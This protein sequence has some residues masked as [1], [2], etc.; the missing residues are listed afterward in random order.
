[1]IN[2]INHSLS[3]TNVETYQVEPYVV[4]ADI[5]SNNNLAGRGGW[6]WYTGSAAW[7]YRVGI[8]DIIG[9]NKIGNEIHLEPH[10]PSE[11]KEFDIE[12]QYNDTKYFIHINCLKYNDVFF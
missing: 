12:Y 5:Y 2:P 9:F 4:A 10:I 3:K 8:I 7:L 1:M 11:W 6:T